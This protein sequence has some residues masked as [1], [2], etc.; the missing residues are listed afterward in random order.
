M[1]DD[2][3]QSLLQHLPYALKQESIPP[4]NNGGEIIPPMDAAIV[5]ESFKR[6]PTSLEMVEFHHGRYL[7][8][9]KLIPFVV[10]LLRDILMCINCWTT[11]RAFYLFAYN[12]V[13]SK[14]NK[15][16]VENLL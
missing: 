4:L 10:C 9:E 6:H 13:I 1:G 16:N 12:R 8:L 7:V 5:F 3:T 14:E 15:A 11:V 2:R